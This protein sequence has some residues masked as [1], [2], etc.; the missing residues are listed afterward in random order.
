M[1]HKPVRKIVIS[2]FANSYFIKA[3]MF[4]FRSMPLKREINYLI[5]YLLI[6]AKYS[7]AITKAI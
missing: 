3:F 6:W 1:L 7:I 2:V 4:L 5:I